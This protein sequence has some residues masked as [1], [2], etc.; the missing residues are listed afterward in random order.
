VQEGTLE[1]QKNLPTKVEY[2]AYEMISDLELCFRERESSLRNY[3]ELSPN[4]TERAMK[5]PG[6]PRREN[7]GIL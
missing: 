1:V 7:T 2:S 3:S 6:T 5:N 4:H